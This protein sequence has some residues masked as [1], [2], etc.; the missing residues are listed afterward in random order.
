[1]RVFLEAFADHGVRQIILI[2]GSAVLEWEGLRTLTYA[3]LLDQLRDM[4]L[5]EVVLIGVEARLHLL[6]G[7]LFE[8]SMLTTHDSEAGHIP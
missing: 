8:S 2:D 6:A 3:P 4:L 7:V 1:V 5:P